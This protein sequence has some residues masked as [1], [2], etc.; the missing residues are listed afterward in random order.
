MLRVRGSL[1]W[2]RCAL[3]LLAL[4]LCA[5]EPTP[6]RF[7]DAA[8]G[9]GID[10]VLRN[11]AT[12]Q[13]QIIETMVGG[14]AAFD[15]DGDG[16][17]DLFLANGAAIP[18]L[19]KNAPR[20]HNRLY[21]NLGGMRFKD[22]TAEAGLTGEGYC[23]G[24]AAADYDNDGRVDLFVS[25]VRGNRL[26]R[27]LGGGKFEDVTEK[28][29]I[30]SGV[31]AI[32]GGWFDYDNDGRL[33]LFVANYLKWSPENPPFCGDPAKKIR[34]YC[35]PRLYEGLPNA[36]YR[37]RGDGTFEDVSA[38]SGIAAHVGKAMSVSFADYDRDGFT[39]IFVTNDKIPSF[40][41]R[42]RGDGRFAEAGLEMGV[43]LPGHGGEVSAMGSD[44]RDYDNDGLP[45]IV[46]A[47]LAGETFPLFKN[48]PRI[49][50]RDWGRRSGLDALTIRRS[51]WSPGLFDFNNDGWKD[52]FVS[53]AHV[54]DTVEAFEAARYKLANSV[55]AGGGGRFQ[56]HSSEAGGDFQVPRA[57]RGAVF[58]DFNNDGRIDVAVS[59]IGETAELWEN[60]SPNENS[61]L[62]L[63]LEGVR[64]N[65][66][67]IGAEVR[68]GDQFNHMTSS[69][70]YASSSL[71]GVHFG[72]GQA[73]T[74]PRIEI[75]WPSGIEQV[76]TG[77]P[78]NQVLKVREPEK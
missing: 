43:A 56:D 37:N 34:S 70:G 64:S 6:I 14:V 1:V 22:V 75:R 45:D 13:K 62:I 18:S 3:Y 55:F 39:D 59:V 47:A 17:T 32:T 77:V 15:Y 28:A 8:S 30:K 24:V 38:A 69:A 21:R 52:L 12:A 54:N 71:F 27:N 67:G 2:P 40:L 49:G 51:G 11:S 65:R 48:F 61:W 44:F 66:D 20:F 9:A 50:F 63:K 31:W 57:H 16:L 58:A 46:F 10:F 42:N 41:F 5:E 72:L 74:A 36:L 29:G 60:V 26:Y 4:A 78:L 73:K 23:H 68:I 76:L 19:E 35:H 53:N 33:D 25:G 7:R